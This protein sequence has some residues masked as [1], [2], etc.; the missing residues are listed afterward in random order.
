MQGV[1]YYIDRSHSTNRFRIFVCGFTILFLFFSKQQ[2]YKQF[3]QINPLLSPCKILN[4]P[5]V[6]RSSCRE[7]IER[8]SIQAFTNPNSYIFLFTV[9]VAT[10]LSDKRG[11]K[12]SSLQFLWSH[13]FE[14]SFAIIIPIIIL[15]GAV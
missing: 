1:D 7:S 3:S 6:H 10:H 15:V 2:F 11:C 5:K 13:R 12:R 9:L 4:Y 8:F 14:S